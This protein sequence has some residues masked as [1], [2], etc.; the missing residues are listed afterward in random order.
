MASPPTWKNQYGDLQVSK[1]ALQA[2]NNDTIACKEALT[3]LLASCTRGVWL[4]LDWDSQAHLLPVAQQLGFRL[5]HTYGSLITLHAWCSPGR[6]PTP[7][8]AHM[9]VG[10]GAL[11]INSQGKMLAIREKFDSSGMYNVPGGHLDEGE[12]WVMGAVREAGEETGVQCYPL[13]ITSM[14]LLHL[15]D[16]LP[17]GA[18]GTSG[19]GVPGKR[20]QALR[21][22]YRAALN[23][24]DAPIE[25]DASRLGAWEHK[26]RWGTGHHAVFTLAYAPTDTL[27]P[28]MGEVAEAVWLEPALFMAHA[29]PYAA[30]FV[31]CA[32]ECGQLASASS[33]A[34]AH[35]ASGEQQGGEGVPSLML[36]TVAHQGMEQRHG[37]AAVP[38]TLDVP[39]TY[40]HAYGRPVLER[41]AAKVAVLQAG[42]GGSTGPVRVLQ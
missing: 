6:N 40:T 12:D 14:R 2:L 29:H 11:V 34:R 22:A 41:A 17:I 5:H 31:S 1:D 36:S 7:Q 18:E 16:T 30:F 20:S 9:S 15:P 4:R 19:E 38:R 35:A 8:Y 28:D 24:T 27:A 10:V 25:W 3:S 39:S 33:C 23:G 21:A 26:M 13:G 32:E 42:L 37:H